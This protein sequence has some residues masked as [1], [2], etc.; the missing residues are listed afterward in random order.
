MSIAQ[1]QTVYR[2]S[3]KRNYTVIGNDLIN[4]PDLSWKAKG[5]VIYLLSKP[6]DWETR[7]GDIVKHSTDG[8]DAVLSG[9]KELKQKGYLEKVRITDPATGRVIRWET[10]V[11]EAPTVLGPDTEN[12][13]SGFP[14][15]GKPDSTKYLKEVSTNTTTKEPEKT[16][17]NSVPEQSAIAPVVVCDTQALSSPIASDNSLPKQV[18]LERPNTKPRLKPSAESSTFSN[19]VAA[20]F[21]EFATN[22]G[23]SLKLTKAFAIAAKG[24]TWGDMMDA[25]QALCE[26]YESAEGVKSQ[27][28]Y[29]IKALREGW[30]ASEEYIERTLASRQRDANSLQAGMDAEKIKGA[31]EWLQGQ[32]EIK[33]LEWSERWYR[34]QL[35][36]S[37]TR[38][39]AE[40]WELPHGYSWKDA[41]A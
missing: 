32:G 37:S 17:K 13:D 31:L 25:L 22:G 10:I 26:Q 28:R 8:R 1:H 2:S 14:E 4:N 40:S 38:Y 18:N 34:Y 12:P 21:V 41:A 7:L 29:F 3:H 35:P 27:Q 30:M 16:I 11:H 15:S 9:L 19:E 39:F 23:W 20:E 33:L 5:I 36:G 6:E 24:K